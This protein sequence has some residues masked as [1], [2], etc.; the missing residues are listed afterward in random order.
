M[1]KTRITSVLLPIGWSVVNGCTVEDGLWTCRRF[2]HEH[3]VIKEEYVYGWRHT[4]IHDKPEANG[5]GV[6]E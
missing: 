6:F 5:L 2:G 4:S 3:L 1:A